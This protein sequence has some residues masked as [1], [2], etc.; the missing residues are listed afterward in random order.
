MVVLSIMVGVFSYTIAARIPVELTIIR[1]RNQLYLTTDNG[2]IENLYQLQLLNMDKNKHDYEI[3][4]D[5]IEGATIVGD[6]VYTLEGGEVRT[7]NLRVRTSPE[8][9]DKP[10]TEL[11]FEAIAK[12]IPSLRAVSESRFMRPL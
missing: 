5:G 1:D 2:D 8:N 11:Q 7:I 3:H 12:D 9:L 6:T 4:I 10:S